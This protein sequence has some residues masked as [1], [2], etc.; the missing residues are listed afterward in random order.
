MAVGRG[1]THGGASQLRQ[2]ENGERE[3]ER[4]KDT[5]RGKGSELKR[6]R[7]AACQ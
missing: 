1:L 7:G 6:E 5:A 4:E 2:T 3:R